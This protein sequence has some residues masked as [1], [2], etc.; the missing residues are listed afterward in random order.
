LI[1]V[2]QNQEQKRLLEQATSHYQQAVNLAEGYLVNRGLSLQ[3]AEYFRLGVVHQPLVGHEAYE[4]RLAIPYITPAGVVDLR[5]RAINHEE[6]KYLSLPGSE[7][8]LYN[9]NALFKATDWIAVC[10]GEIDTITLTKLGIPAV[11]VPGVK[12]I[13]SHHY[14][15]LAD[16]QR[17]YVFADGDP[18]GKEFTKELARKVSGVT[19]IAIPEGEDVNSLFTKQ[20]SDWFRGK[21]A[22]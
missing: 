4:G 1:F 20:G 11:G 16:F 14:R 2:K 7:T 15:I 19:P 9:V 10:E 13:K 8:R 3:D 22:A 17:I 18:A 5:F 6:P 21:V 12:N